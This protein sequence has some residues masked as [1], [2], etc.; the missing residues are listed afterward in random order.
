MILRDLY[1]ICRNFNEINELIKKKF[2]K[3]YH[4]CKNL[5]QIQ[6]ERMTI[7]DTFKKD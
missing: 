5:I 6:I 1:E 2:R 3:K 4:F 7:I